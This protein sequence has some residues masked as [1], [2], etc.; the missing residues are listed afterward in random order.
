M[1]EGIGGGSPTDWGS[2]ERTRQSEENG[3]CP[4]CLRLRAK[5]SNQRPSLQLAHKLLL[6][7]TP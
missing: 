2:T 5:V 6:W 4:Y 3:P 1:L 7:R